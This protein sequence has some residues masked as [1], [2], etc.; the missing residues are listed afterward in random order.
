MKCTDEVLFKDIEVNITDI[1]Q[2]LLN[3]DNKVRSNLFSWNG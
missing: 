1:D 3:I 2:A